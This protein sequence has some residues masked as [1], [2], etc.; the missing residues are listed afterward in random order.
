M[1][2]S[3]QC[4]GRTSGLAGARLHEG[5][6]DVRGEELPPTAVLT[7]LGGLRAVGDRPARLAAI[8]FLPALRWDDRGAFQEELADLAELSRHM[9]RV[10]A[11]P[12]LVGFHEAVHE[13]VETLERFLHG[14]PPWAERIV[15]RPVGPPVSALA[16]SRPRLPGEHA[17]RR[18]R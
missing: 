14:G 1:R 3:R 6:L 17:P 12:G 16:T 7:A 9:E 2:P 13:G 18:T 8:V 11:R 4:A 15:G 5:L 10:D